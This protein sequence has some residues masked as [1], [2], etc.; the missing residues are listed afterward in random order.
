MKTRKNKK[1]HTKCKKGS[2]RWRFRWPRRRSTRVHPKPIS[3]ALN[4]PVTKLEIDLEAAPTD[5]GYKKAMKKARR[6]ELQYIMDLPK[7]QYDI[8]MNM[9]YWSPNTIRKYYDYHIKRNQRNKQR[10]EQTRR[11]PKRHTHSR[12]TSAYLV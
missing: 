9:Y 7:H 8:D 12:H 2:G 10:Q 3:P 6:E 5:Y 4:R 1:R 11:K